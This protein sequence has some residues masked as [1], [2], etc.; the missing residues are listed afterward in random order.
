MPSSWSDDG[1]QK[2]ANSKTNL[3]R[4]DV[5]SVFLKTIVILLRSK[6]FPK[7][8]SLRFSGLE[9]V[10]HCLCLLDNTLYYF[11]SICYLRVN[12]INNCEL[13]LEPTLLRRPLSNRFPFNGAQ[14]R[15]NKPTSAKSFH[16]P[17]RVER[18]RVPRLPNRW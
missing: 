12:L 7:I 13:V 18:R 3:I 11:L 5:K 2:V 4:F 8:T 14:A 16:S 10:H 1:R 15:V 17:R 9:V 6:S